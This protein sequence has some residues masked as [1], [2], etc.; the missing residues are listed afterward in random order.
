MWGSE[1]GFRTTRR[2]S[3]PNWS[4]TNPSSDATVN[5]EG[6]VAVAAGSAS[7]AGAGVS[8][9]GRSPWLADVEADYYSPLKQNLTTRHW[10]GCAALLL[11]AAH[12][13]QCMCMFID[14]VA[15]AAD[16]SGTE[17]ASRDH[18]VAA[19]WPTDSCNNNPTSKVCSSGSIMCWIVFIVGYYVITLLLSIQAR[20]SFLSCFLFSFLLRFFEHMR[21]RYFCA[22]FRQAVLEIS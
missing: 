4:G 17:G 15:P 1:L 13:R 7:A 20:E 12:R 22:S 2:R 5:L 11:P 21:S 18:C 14:P 9:M 19:A 3:W 6:A 10:R 16:P 8:N